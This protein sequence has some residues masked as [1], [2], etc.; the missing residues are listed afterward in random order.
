ME[1]VQRTDPKFNEAVEQLITVG[2]T[3]SQIARKSP[4]DSLLKAL[5][6]HMGLLTQHLI[7][8][9]KNHSRCE[10]ELI[11]EGL[12]PYLSKLDSRMHTDPTRFAQI[13][14]IIEAIVSYRGDHL[15]VLLQDID[16]VLLEIKSNRAYLWKSEFLITL[17]AAN[18]KQWR[19]IIADHKTALQ[20]VGGKMLILGLI[21]VVGWP[22]ALLYPMYRMS[23]N[24]LRIANEWENSKRLTPQSMFELGK[25]A[26]ILFAAMQLL[27]IL[28]VY[29]A[30][31]HTSLVLGI[32]SLVA[33]QIP[34]VIKVIAPVLAPHLQQIDAIVNQLEGFDFLKL[35]GVNAQA[36]QHVGVHS[37][38]RTGTAT[39]AGNDPMNYQQQQQPNQEYPTSSRVEEISAAA[40]EYE[41]THAQSSIPVAEEVSGQEGAYLH[42][43]S[44]IDTADA[45][46]QPIEGLRRRNY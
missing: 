7:D 4:S 8:P 44:G 23:M 5:D 17:Q 19:P 16:Q 32:A 24:L 43:P 28:S 25:T 45:Y 42:S 46:S 22:M 35:T 11:V 41:Y 1:L 31:G 18:D 6:T 2:T 38:N 14:R 12:V 20:N 37:T 13:N 3:V 21:G 30:V 33:S 15:A 29:A 26:A 34:D 40:Y 36:G 39:G 10:V 9:T 27:K